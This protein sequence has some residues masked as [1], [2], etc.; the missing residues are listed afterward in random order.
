MTLALTSLPN[1]YPNGFIFAKAGEA[2]ATGASK[3]E[4]A[5]RREA[6]TAPYERRGW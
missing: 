2:D 3:L 5:K 4:Q 1:D 6:N